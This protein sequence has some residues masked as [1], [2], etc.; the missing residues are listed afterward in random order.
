MKLYS[1]TY[2]IDMHRNDDTN[3]ISNYSRRASGLLSER[4]YFGRKIPRFT[5]EFNPNNETKASTAES[6]F[7]PTENFDQCLFNEGSM[8]DNIENQSFKSCDESV[9]GIHNTTEID[10]AQVAKDHK[11]NP[12]SSIR[13]LISFILREIDGINRQTNR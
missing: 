4:G 2:D 3:S 13:N 5:E 6:T 11:Y 9:E 7:I 10:Q 1:L 12:S 8:S